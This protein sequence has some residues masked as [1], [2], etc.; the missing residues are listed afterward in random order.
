MVQNGEG[1]ARDS[2]RNQNTKGKARGL[3][4]WYRTL[5][6]AEGQVRTKRSEITE[7]VFQPGRKA[8]AAKDVVS[9]LEAYE[10]DIREYQILT[11]NNMDNTMMEIYQQKMMPDVIPERVETLDL[12]SDAEAKEYATKQA[13]TLKRDSTSSTP[14]LNENEEEMEDKKKNTR[15]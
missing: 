11:G 5:R 3:I 6:E 7:K 13:R 15:F 2:H 8:V 4:A 10:G 12:Q 9:T 14:Y 1:P